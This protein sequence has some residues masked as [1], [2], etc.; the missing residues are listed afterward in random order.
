MKESALASCEE[1][2]PTAKQGFAILQSILIM[3]LDLS[4]SARYNQNVT[5]GPTSRAA[6]ARSPT[7]ADSLLQ[8]DA[9]DLRSQFTRLYPGSKLSYGCVEHERR[10]R[11]PKEPHQP[12]FP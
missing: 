3:G 1:G 8:A 4:E 5:S 11:S 9:G 2:W 6:D 7:W 10:L 12:E